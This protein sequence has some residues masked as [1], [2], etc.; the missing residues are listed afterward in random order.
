MKYCP[1]CG[2]LLDGKNECSCGFVIDEEE[3]M[4]N[5]GSNTIGVVGT[6]MMN[7]FMTD[8]E[9]KFEELLKNSRLDNNDD[10]EDEKTV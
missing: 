10:K 5:P 8:E 2:A 6:G 4:E 3:L 7:P 9:I 1:K